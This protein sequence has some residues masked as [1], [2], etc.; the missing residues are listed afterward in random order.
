MRRRNC[1]ACA[2]DCCSPQAQA[3][4]LDVRAL[5]PIEVA[6]GQRIRFETRVCPTVN[7]TRGSEIDAYLAA[8]D[9]DRAAPPRGS[10]YAKWLAERLRGVS[11][12]HVRMG[13]FLLAPAFR[14]THG[15]GR[16]WVPRIYPD[17]TLRGVA[18]VVDPKLSAETLREGVGGSAP[19]AAAGCGRRRSERPPTLRAISM[20]SWKSIPRVRADAPAE[21]KKLEAAAAYSPCARMHRSLAA[22]GPTNCC[23]PRVRADAPAGTRSAGMTREHSPRARGCTAATGAVRR[24]P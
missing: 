7:R 8:I 4:V 11:V 14:P 19:M 16:R 5:P 20:D 12:H 15:N 18:T 9:G 24:P 23:I 13:A 1:A 2:L 3:V 21:R 17:V 6:M 22:P 10:V